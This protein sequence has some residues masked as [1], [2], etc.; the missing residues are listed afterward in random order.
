MADGACAAASPDGES[1]A[2]A[3]PRPN[4]RDESPEPEA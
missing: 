2:F 3:M 1:R 4:V